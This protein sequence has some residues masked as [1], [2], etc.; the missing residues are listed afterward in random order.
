VIVHRNFDDLFGHSVVL[1]QEGEAAAFGLANAVMLAKPQSAFLHRWLEQYKSFRSVGYR[2]AKF[3]GD[4][5][6]ISRI[7]RMCCE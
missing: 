4:R 1:G 7:A 5:S 6:F 2:R 3:L